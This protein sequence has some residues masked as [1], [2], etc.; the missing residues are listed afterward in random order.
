MAARESGADK[1]PA[2][3]LPKELAMV[4][5]CLQGEAINPEPGVTGG[6]EPMCGVGR[7]AAKWN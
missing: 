1:A 5:S 2:Q 3:S 7:G 6:R 4:T